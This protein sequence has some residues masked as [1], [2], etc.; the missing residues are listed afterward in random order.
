MQQDLDAVTA[1]LFD[2]ATAVP[3]DYAMLPVAK[4]ESPIYR[5]RV[6]CYELYHQWRMRWRDQWPYSLSGE[7]DK[8]GHPIVRPNTK[9]DFLV[10]D[11]GTMRNL[12]ALEVKPA[13]TS[14]KK[15]LKDLR[16][17]TYLRRDLGTVSATS[18]RIFGSTWSMTGVGKGSLRS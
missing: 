16:T 15:A 12:L 2:A 13:N 10:H 18:R 3:A 17:L 7:I 5:E 9:P 4:R 14:I 1:A 11:P 6:Y 8:A